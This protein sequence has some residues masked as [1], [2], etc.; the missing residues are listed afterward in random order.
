MSS[1]YF[2]VSKISCDRMRRW[3][4]RLTKNTKCTTYGECWRRHKKKELSQIWCLT[5]D[6]QK[7][8]KTFTAIDRNNIPS[9]V[10]SI[11]KREVWRYLN[12]ATLWL[13]FT[14][15]DLITN[16][17][18]SR[19]SWMI[20]DGKDIYLSVWYDSFTPQK[21]LRTL[22]HEIITWIL[23][24]TWTKDIAERD[25]SM[26]NDSSFSYNPTYSSYIDADKSLLKQWFVS[27]YACTTPS[28]DLSEIAETLMAW[29]KLDGVDIRALDAQEYPILYKKVE[30]VK[31][32]L[33][34]YLTSPFASTAVV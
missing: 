6:L 4:E 20:V 2:S 26:Y 23:R 15:V 10:L 21:F 29:V 24:Q 8:W 12:L 27:T 5:K 16:D 25:I 14:Y 34:P 3:K 28:N 9:E 13:S 1:C 33:E 17:Q 22:H 19:S 11:A 18:D 31:W 32:Y 30:L 7:Y